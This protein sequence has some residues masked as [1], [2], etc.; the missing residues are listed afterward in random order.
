MFLMKKNTSICPKFHGTTLENGYRT[1]KSK[2][3]TH[4]GI[5]STEK[6]KSGV[7]IK[8]KYISIAL[9]TVCDNCQ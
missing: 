7:L 4:F 5:M 8:K 9:H 2:F 1:D 6:I 3:Y